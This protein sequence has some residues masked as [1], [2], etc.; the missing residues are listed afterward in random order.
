MWLHKI[1]REKL[2]RRLNPSLLLHFGSSDKTQIVTSDLPSWSMSND[3]LFDL[4]YKGA[5][6]A[7]NGVCAE[8]A[9]GEPSVQNGQ[10]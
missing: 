6:V 8:L 9:S 7:L 10:S 3:G 2:S 5:N 1:E 4:D